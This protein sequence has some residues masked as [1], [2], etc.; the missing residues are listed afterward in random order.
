MEQLAQVQQQAATQEQLLKPSVYEQPPYSQQAYGQYHP[1][2]TLNEMPD[3]VPGPELPA[4]ET[5]VSELPSGGGER[6][7][8][9]PGTSSGPGSTF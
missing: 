6:R 1:C 5:A 2:G 7:W 8:L 4:T 9:S 3:G